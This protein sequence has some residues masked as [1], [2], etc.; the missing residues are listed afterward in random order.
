MAE[1]IY[2]DITLDV[3]GVSL[4]HPLIKVKQN[5][6]GTR[7]VRAT[8]LNDKSPF[9]ISD[10]EEI[11]IN[12]KRTNDQRVNTYEGT[13][14]QDGRVQFTI[15]SWALEY[16]YTVKCDISIVERNNDD[17]AKLTTNDFYIQVEETTITNS[18]QQDD[19][20]INYLDK[21]IQE[22]G[23][24]SDNYDDGIERIENF[25]SEFDADIERVED[26]EDNYNA[27]I[28][29]IEAAE[30][31]ISGFSQRVNTLETG[32]ADKT[33]TITGTGV[34]SGGGDLS[35]NRTITHNEI[36]GTAKTTADVYKIKIDKYGHITEA[37]SA[38]LA[39][40]A[41]SGSY[42]DLSDQPAIN[43]GT[44]TIQV[45]GTSKGTFTANQAGN[46]TINITA[47]SLGLS[48]AMKFIGT[49]TTQISDGAT[50]NPVTIN[51][52]SVTATGGNVVLYNNKEFLWNSSLSTPAWE[53]LG[54]E[55]S[56][57][58]KTVTI[59][60][61]GV[62]GGG[63]SLEANRTITHN[64]G[65]A[66]SKAS[67]FY[68]FSTDAYSHIGG[69]TAVVKKDLTDL[70]TS[71]AAASGG[72]DLSLATTGEKYVWNNK[73]TYSK[74]SGGIPASDLAE[75]YYLASNP[76]GYTSNAGT[77]T[78]VRVQAGT[79]LSSSQSTAQTGTLNTTISVASGYKLPT[80][81][82]W[83]A[84]AD[85]NSYLPLS[86]GSGKPLTG[87]LY[88]DQSG[89]SQ[90][91][92][93]TSGNI[94]GL[95][96]SGLLNGTEKYIVQQADKFYFGSIAN[97]NRVIFDPVNKGL[98]T[99]TNA[100]VALGGY[101]NRWSRTITETANAY[102]YSNIATSRPTSADFAHY[103]DANYVTKGRIHTR[104]D[105][106]SGNMT[107]S[108]PASDGYIQTFFWDN[109]GMYD[110]QL[111][112]PNSKSGNNG[113]P[114]IRWNAGANTGTA[115]WNNW[116]NVALEKDVS[117]FATCTTEA[118]TKDKVA[119]ISG[120]EDYVLRVGAI[121]GVKF[122]NT[123]TFNAS[124]TAGY[125]TLNVNGTGAKNIWWNNTGS[126]T[127]TNTKAFGYANRTIY[128]MYDGTYWVFL[129][130]STDDNSTGY[131]SYTATSV[132]NT[133]TNTQYLIGKRTVASN[134]T[135]YY[136]S[137]IYFKGYNLYTYNCY[138]TSDRRLK[139]NIK[140]AELDCGK[141]IDELPIK[142]FNFKSDEEKKVVVGAIA[143]EL[144]E[145]LPEKYRATLVSG[146]EDSSYSINEGKLLFV[147]I[148][149]LKEERAKTKELEERL[150]RLEAKLGV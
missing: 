131:L 10:G 142:E 91:I 111:F 118:A 141:V 81:T 133:D 75:T 90:V 93:K 67:G 100:N 53:E 137:S 143:Q 115:N 3:S 50:T 65:N 97:A 27:G 25:E 114:Q 29:R 99:E 86:A 129:S 94:T 43:N 88:F 119:T 138:A 59:T 112:V 74:P 84:K 66:V 144:Q 122:T 140:P 32:K 30:G 46:T 24:L 106:A 145:I 63:G 55:S 128:Y 42:N 80:T 147:A 51:G 47:A 77:V 41:T 130:A 7:G 2:S 31:I 56:H 149:A 124:A 79:G 83:N 52:S 136:N 104:I 15:P 107:T 126:P 14:L 139:E 110:V 13:L 127:G 123:N 135:N 20:I 36:L 26:L 96:L 62:L 5:D 70:I 89:Q 57:A 9:V 64:A 22:V 95:I 82:E 92:W 49:T 38:G 33:I 8:I 44:L 76:N 132:D 120:V 134:G 12:F 117:H 105:V 87:D 69:V 146:S 78:R 37:V 4:Q 34:L 108:K 98:Y 48:S 109:R 28:I 68:K 21:L 71:M 102:Y 18:D 85:A 58:L 17:Y 40:V 54:D 45:E 19:D 16:P 125:V 60:G 101:S 150:A 148:G 113:H 103:Y 6:R 23:E 1:I 61:T 121:V 11:L 35:Q 72:T 39:A 73:G 116:A